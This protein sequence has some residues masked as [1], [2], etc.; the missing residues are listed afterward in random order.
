M[1]SPT[2]VTLVSRALLLLFSSVLLFIQSNLS[3]LVPSLLLFLLK[4]SPCSGTFPSFLSDS[5]LFCLS[6]SFLCQFFSPSL[7]SRIAI[8]S[9]ISF[10]SFLFSLLAFF[11]LLSFPLV[12][13]VLFPPARY[14]SPLI[15]S[16]SPLLCFHFSSLIYP[17]SFPLCTLIPLISPAFILLPLSPCLTF[18]SSSLSSFCSQMCV[19]IYSKHV[20]SLFPLVSL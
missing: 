18:L 6:T 2:L 15:S 8:D 4:F 16:I 5:V 20:L 1:I 17:L 19:H 3:L 13:S 10:L 12:S 11:P 9:Y 7:L 14:L